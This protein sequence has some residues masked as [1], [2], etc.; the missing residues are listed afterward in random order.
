[1]PATLPR[2]DVNLQEL[3][4][5]LDHAPEVPLT[6][7]ECQ[8]LKAVVHTFA[9]VLRLLDEQDTTIARLREWLG[10]S[11][12][13][14][15]RHVLQQAGLVIPA[16]ARRATSELP[17]AA[18]APGH[19]RYGAAAYTG[20][21]TIRIPHPTLRPGDRCPLCLRGKV[22]AQDEPGVLVRVVG[23][24][25]L[26]A[27]VYTPDK[28]RCNLCGEIFTASP[29][30]DVGPAKYE[31]TA[32]A[33]IAL[34]KYGTG[35][36]FKRLAQLQDSLGVPLPPAT[37]WELL[38]HTAVLLQPVLDELIYQAAQG[39]VLHNDD[40]A[41]K[42]LAL[43]Q[44]EPRDE[45]PGTPRTGTFTSGIVATAAGHKIALFFTGPKHAGENLAAVL[46]HR[47][48]ELGPPIQ[49]CDAL[50]RNLPKPLSVLLA[51]CLAHGRRQFVAVAP[52]FPT[53][54]RH[55]LEALG[56]VYRVDAL[57][58]AQALSP[59]ERLRMHQIHSGPVMTALQAWLTVQLDEKHVEPNSG[60]GKAITYLLKHW[61]ALTLFLRQPGAP[62]DNNIVERAL[63]KAILHRKNALF[64]R[65]Q[66]GARVG[67]LFMALIHTC[68][69]CGANPFEYLT[70]LQRHAAELATNPGK[71]LPWTYRE[72]LTRAGC[73]HGPAP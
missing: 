57:A 3:E 64:Y 35:V 73:E 13:E 22:Y 7:V 20:A 1:M 36:P 42:V 39:D 27:T 15:T 37:Q 31:V 48:V 63:K 8:T 56:D 5:R 4:R 14:K 34:L 43:R 9:D 45:A 67:D 66:N 17:G 12:T 52:N 29:P 32:I 16:R 44:A 47:A 33:M 28:L 72:T 54:C 59:D 21:R 65:T 11:H 55:V 30:T 10:R 40:T 46:A 71:W 61:D 19:G 26:G 41:M 53:E 60:L 49:M 25:P 24:V 23:Q 70:E 58:R 62:L 6:P 18:A 2:L 51:N 50:T 68:E 69:L 38:K